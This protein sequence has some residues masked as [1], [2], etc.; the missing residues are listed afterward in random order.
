[1]A[2]N[3]PIAEPKA[4]FLFSECEL[5]MAMKSG[6]CTLHTMKQSTFKGFCDMG[7]LG[8]PH[9]DPGSVESWGIVSSAWLHMI[10]THRIAYIPFFS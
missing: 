2:E 1:M 7:L 4:R 6:Q 3:H 9:E 10:C 8:N 5:E